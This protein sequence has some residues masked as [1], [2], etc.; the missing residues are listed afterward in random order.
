MAGFGT[1]FPE[2]FECSQARKVYYGS[3]SSRGYDVDRTARERDRHK[4]KL[5]GKTR[6]APSPGKGHPRKSALSRQYKCSCGHTGWSC[7]ID[8]ERRTTPNMR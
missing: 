6:D 5:T 8:L 7:H 2:F 3:R 1:G 4:V